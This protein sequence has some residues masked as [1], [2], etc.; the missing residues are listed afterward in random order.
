MIIAN[1]NV[2]HSLVDSPYNKRR[3]SCEAAAAAMA[4][5]NPDAGITHLR[6]CTLEMLE[7]VKATLSEEDFKR[8]RH[9]ISEDVRTITAGEPCCC[10][11]FAA[12]AAAAHR[13]ALVFHSRLAHRG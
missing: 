12:A 11:C 13:N 8:A 6:D 7:G 9:G 2:A 10:C 5:A 4:K 3:V 1:T